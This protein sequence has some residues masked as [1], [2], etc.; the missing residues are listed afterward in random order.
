M[1]KLDIKTYLASH[2]GKPVNRLFYK[3]MRAFVAGP[4]AKK[5]NY[6]VIDNVGV[7]DLKGPFIVVSNHTSRC[8]W[9]YVGCALYPQPMNYM[10]SDIEFHRAHMHLIF[11]LCRVI[12]KKNFVADFHC[13]REIKSVISKG[14]NVIFFP[15]TSTW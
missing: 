5:M 13:I 9:E 3:I 7:K 12:P 2:K 4:Q 1:G 14:G 11:K 15:A 8:D 6:E 10:A